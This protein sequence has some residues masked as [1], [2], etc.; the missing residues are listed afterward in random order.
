MKNPTRTPLVKHLVLIGGGHSH[1]AVLRKLGMSPLPGLTVTVIT[2]DIEIPYS[3]SLPNYLSGNSSIDEMHLDLR[4]LVQFAG[5]RLIQQTVT[6]IDFENRKISLKKRPVMEFDFISINIGSKPELSRIAGASTNAIAVKPLANFIKRWD[7]ILPTMIERIGDGKKCS[8]VI[9]GGG[10]ASVEIAFAIH[11]RLKIELKSKKNLH[12]LFCISLIT[13]ESRLLAQHNLKASRIAHAELENHGVKIVV[14]QR[15][16]NIDATSVTSSSGETYLSDV[17]IIATGAGMQTWPSKSGLKCNPS[18]FIEVNSFLQ[19]VSHPHVFASGDAASMVGTDLPKSGV[20]AVRQGKPLAENIFRYITERKL[21]AYKPQNHVLALLSM[22]NKVAIAS[23][24]PL[25]VKNKGAWILKNFIDRKFI[26]KYTSLP[27][28]KIELNLSSGMLPQSEAKELKNHAMRCAGCGAKVDSSIL[29]SVLTDLP[30]TPKAEILNR[31]VEDASIISLGNNRQL[32]QS[33]DQINSFIN[34]PWLFA[35]IAT[36]HCL[37]DIYAM[38]AQP[39]SALASIGL[40]MAS[41]S[42]TKRMLNE[43]MRGCVD[44]LEENDVTLIGGHTAE[45]SEMQ[46]GLAVNGFA[47]SDA[48]MKKGGM[49]SE[50]RLI[51]TKP[52]GSGTLLAADMRSKA[53]NSWIQAALTEM[54]ASNLAASQIFLSMNATS[55]TDITGFGL[56]GHLVEMIEASK[57]NIEIFLDKVPVLKGAPECMENGIYSSLHNSNKESEI[58]ITNRDVFRDNKLYELLFD[59]QTA[60][61]LLASV[62]AEKATETLKLIHEAGY[63]EAQI[64]GRVANGSSPLPTIKLMK[65]QV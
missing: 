65:S 40:P 44:A 32:I 23:R 56:A 14:G 21:K 10:P 55:C 30:I 1:L 26:E 52:I 5:A 62:S 24:G 43:I 37:S 58:V 34:D 22:S 29:S 41:Q 57:S 35:R 31:G 51:I 20:Y 39:H 6:S 12:E 42:M 54:L 33:I 53:K 28:M 49:E 4:P 36:N 25:A 13:A 63:R 17:C 19:S 48:V 7:S 9:V 11:K 59:P 50:D 38:G 64:I 16:K 46:I 15:I 3:G 27:E 60:G 18:G 8:F 45:T 2:T 61:G 47:S